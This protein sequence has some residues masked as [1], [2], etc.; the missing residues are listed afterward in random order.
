MLKNRFATRIQAFQKMLE[1][2]LNDETSIGSGSGS[3]GAGGTG[4]QTTHS[5]A[6][7]ATGS[8]QVISSASEPRKAARAREDFYYYFDHEDDCFEEHDAGRGAGGRAATGQRSTTAYATLR[9]RA[10]DFRAT[11]HDD[12]NEHMLLFA[13]S[14][15]S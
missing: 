9:K 15:S 8:A 6:S 11:S 2:E 10:D 3:G 12:A 13:T 7:C 14:N 1:E 4:E 5:H